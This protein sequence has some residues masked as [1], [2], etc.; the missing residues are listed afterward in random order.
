[1][2][3]IEDIEVNKELKEKSAIAINQ[4]LKLEADG[5]IFQEV[6]DILSLLD[7]HIDDFIQDISEKPTFKARFA[8]ILQQSGYNNTIDVNGNIKRN[9]IQS[10]RKLF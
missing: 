3:D 5:D 1:M 8:E 4:I 7:I 6:L 2:K 9:V 10:K